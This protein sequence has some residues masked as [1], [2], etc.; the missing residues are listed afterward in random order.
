MFSFQTAHRRSRVRFGG[1]R[2]VVT[3][4]GNGDCRQVTVYEAR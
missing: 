1:S 3:E 4:H 2:G